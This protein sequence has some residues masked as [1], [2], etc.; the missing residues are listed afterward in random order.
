MTAT[1]GTLSMRL[2]F[3]GEKVIKSQNKDGVLGAIARPWGYIGHRREGRRK[4]KSIVAWGWLDQSRRRD[5]MVES[6]ES[7]V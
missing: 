5:L 3:H 4:R 6:I 7:G 2:V 1:T